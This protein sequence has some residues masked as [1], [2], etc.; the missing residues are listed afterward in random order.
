MKKE[1]GINA[2]S[3][4]RKYYLL[5]FLLI[6][7][8]IFTFYYFFFHFKTGDLVY[9]KNLNTIGEIAGISPLKLG[10]LVYW[11]DG[12]YTDEFVFN[13]EKVEQ[14]KES[15]LSQNS[16][17]N[18]TRPYL[19]P[20]KAENINFSKT[21]FNELLR[22][23][24]DNTDNIYGQIP[25]KTKIGICIPNLKCGDWSDC[26]VNYNFESLINP[27]RI[28]GLEY[29]SCTDLNKCIP[30][31]I[32]SRACISKI[33]VTVSTGFWCGRE[34]T[35]VMDKNGKIVARLDT[36]N[37]SN[38]LDVN[39]NL[40]EDYCFYCYDQKKNYDETDVDCGGSCKSCIN[41]KQKI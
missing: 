15:N 16:T 12:T 5:S 3:G 10:Y 11:Q 25:Q 35:E 30:D 26:Q 32:G 31:I 8:I 24:I 21:L 13:L 6:L 29:K 9:K 1:E 23:K 34:Y 40:G 18:K 38:Y 22:E 2:F 37:Q 28:E 19:P 17:Q 7:I 27:D 4:S 39:I 33:N 41:G 36:K 14:I 20:A